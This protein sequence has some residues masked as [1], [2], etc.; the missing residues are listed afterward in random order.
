MWLNTYQVFNNTTNCVEGWPSRERK[1][2]NT[3]G[4]MAMGTEAA[5]LNRRRVQVLT[6]KAL[7]RTPSE[8]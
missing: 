6:T 7:S 1:G 2:T 4:A 8:T 5:K 3:S